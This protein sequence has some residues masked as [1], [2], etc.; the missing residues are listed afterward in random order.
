MQ[1][2]LQEL[3]SDGPYKEKYRK[4][5]ID[6]SDEVRKQSYGYFCKTAMEKAN[7]E[8]IVVSDVRRMNDIRYFRET[9]GDKV[10]CVRLTCPEAVRVQRGFIYTTG[11]DDIESE[12]GLDN[13]KNWDL[14]LE[15]DNKLSSNNLIESIIQTFSL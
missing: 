5:M 3:L 4:D 14:I 7:S 9:Y 15:N 6:W 11:I 12:C 13:F 10:V 2:D 1:L 8:I